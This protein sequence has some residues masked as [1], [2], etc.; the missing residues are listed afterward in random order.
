MKILYGIQGTGNGH[1]SRA[2]DIIPALQKYGEVDLLVSGTQADVEL[3]YNINYKCHGMSFVFGKKGGVDYVETYKRSNVKKLFKEISR[4]PV[5]DY[6]L[7][8]SDF[9]PVTAWACFIRNKPC[10]GLSHQLGVSCKRSP[11]PDKKDPIGRAVLKH[12]APV[13]QE[14]GFHF[15]P[16][17]KNIFTPIIRSEIRTLLLYNSGH[18]TVYLPSFNEERIIKFLS[19]FPEV[20]WEIFSKHCKESF[21]TEHL[22]VYPVNNEAF[23]KS[24]AGAEGVLCGAGFETPAEV[25]FLQKKLMVIPMKG[26]YEQQCNAAA[27]KMLGVPA[28]KNL[29]PKQYRTFHHWLQHGKPVYLDFPDETQYIVDTIIK[30]SLEAEGSSI[31]SDKFIDKPSRFRDLVLRKI[32]YQP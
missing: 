10:V 31:S 25:L 8:I 22:S 23:L 21:T 18:Y 29:K 11:K 30:K 27:L 15:L 24:L 16:Y 6:D 19:C 28:M 20:Q 17:A 4:L 14:Y 5:H 26:Q 12:Y 9:E 32:F 13:T 3:P 7:V 2:R 1:L